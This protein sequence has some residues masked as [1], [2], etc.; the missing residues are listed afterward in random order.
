MCLRRTCS[1]TC[2]ST[3]PPYL[4]VRWRASVSAMITHIH[5]HLRDNALVAPLSV[6]VH[7][8]HKSRPAAAPPSSSTGLANA[9]TAAIWWRRI[10]EITAVSAPPGPV[11]TPSGTRS[12]AQTRSRLPCAPTQTKPY[13]PRLFLHL[14]RLPRVAAAQLKGGRSRQ[15]RRH[16]PFAG[17]PWVRARGG[18]S[19]QA[20]LHGVGVTFRW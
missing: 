1:C 3:Q 6:C 20:A 9:I 12:P 17:G 15:H 10:S 19:S 16:L 13:G 4:L 7:A 11:R 8:P 14:P 18:G 5:L 2:T